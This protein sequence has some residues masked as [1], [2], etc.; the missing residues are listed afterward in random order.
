MTYIKMQSDYGTGYRV[1]RNRFDSGFF[2]WEITTFVPF[3][4][5]VWC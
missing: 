3:S 4:A 5:V 2:R 1:T